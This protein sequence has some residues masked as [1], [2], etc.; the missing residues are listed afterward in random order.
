MKLRKHSARGV[1]RHTEHKERPWGLTARPHK[2]EVW[3]AADKASGMPP[4]A[5]TTGRHAV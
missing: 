4:T 5:Y 2:A 1:K 3:H